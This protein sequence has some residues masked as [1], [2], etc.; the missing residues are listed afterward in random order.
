MTEFGA[1][2]QSAINSIHS[3]VWEDKD[4][5]IIKLM[6]APAE[7]LQKWY[8]H[9][10]E[11]LHNTSLQSSGKY[12]V[13]NSIRNLWSACNTELFVRDLIYERDT[14]LKTKKDIL[15]YINNLRTQH[16][17][18]ILNESISLI[19]DNLNPV[20]EKITISKLMDACFDKLG[21]F[22]KKLIGSKFLLYQGIW[23]TDEEKVE[24]TE[25]DENGRMRSWND[26]IKERLS[27]RNPNHI[28]IRFNPGGF[29]YHEFRSI[30]QLPLLPK[31]STLPTAT[32]QTLRDK[33]LLLVEND[34]LSAIAKWEKI[35]SNIV[36][37]ANARKI[38]LDISNE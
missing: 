35:L 29:S 15:D 31:I 3:Y 26:V 5:N 37:V 12:V 21:V 6:D 32:L 11:M 34:C 22:S 24:L 13:L 19:F 8:N 10:Y 36:E 4:G 23:L 28:T 9:A 27:I 30:F 16:Q 1:S 33:V 38:P 7:N 2:L 14:C 25:R 20:F 17:T 18:D